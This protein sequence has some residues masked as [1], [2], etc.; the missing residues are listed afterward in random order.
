MSVRHWTLRRRTARQ[1][2]WT[3]SLYLLLVGVLSSLAHRAFVQHQLDEELE[4]QLDEFLASYR[5]GEGGPEALARLAEPLGRAEAETPLA[6]VVRNERSGEVWGPHGPQALVRMLESEPAPE[7]I[8]RAAG[9]RRSFRCALDA[10]RQLL[11]AMDGAEWVARIR[12][13]DLL[14]LGIAGSGALLSFA[15]GALYGGRIARLLEDVVHAVDQRESRMGSEQALEVPDAPDEIRALVE[16]IE[17]SLRETRR[18]VERAQVLAAGLAHD[19]R[20]PVQSLLTSTQVALQ[21]P[22]SATQSRALL[23]EHQVQLRVL[24]RTIDNLVTW[25]SPKRGAGEHARVRVDLGREFEARLAGEEQEAARRGVFV[26]VERSGSLELDCDPRALVLAVRNLV[27]NAIAWSPTGGQVRVQLRGSSESV[28]ILV[29]DQGPGVPAAERERIFRPFVRGAAAP[30][31]RAGYGLGLAIVAY[32]AEQHGGSARV[33][34]AA[35][36]SARFVLR[37][38]RAGPTPPST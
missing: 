20:A 16:S 38:P 8:V 27:G 13:V 17:G 28:E 36:S 18:E 22:D 30:G 35:G 34:D 4:E 37:L 2:T 14:L 11:V 25:G 6:L 21:G 26:D 5:A 3:A 29:E 12:A 1:F 31:Q 32:V 24:A 33:E 10:E 23:E 9:G 15:A 7:R 19:L